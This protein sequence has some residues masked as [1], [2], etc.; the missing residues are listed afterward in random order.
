MKFSYLFKQARVVLTVCTLAFAG[1]FCGKTIPV[2]EMSE[3]RLQ[4]EAAEQEE[5]PQHSP[6]NYEQARDALLSA[7]KSLGEEDYDDARVSAVQATDLAIAAR[8]QAAPLMMA[9]RQAK[10]SE[11]LEAADEAYAE[12]LAAQDFAAAKSLYS[13]GE[14]AKAAAAEKGDSSELL[15]DRMAVLT[16][17]NTAGRKFTDAATAAERA[18]NMSLAQKG[19]MLDSLDGIRSNLKKAEAWGAGDDEVNEL[20]AA[21]ATLSQAEKEINAGELKKANGTMQEAETLSKALLAK[22]A[23]QHAQKK[24]AEA[25]AAVKKADGDFA[26]VNTENNR[27]DEEARDIL[28]TINAQ[29]TAAKEA[30]DSAESYYNRDNAQQSISESEDAI[31]L[32]QIIF[33]QHNLLAAAQKRDPGEIGEG[34]DDTDAEGDA[35]ADEKPEGWREYTVVRKSPADCLWC[36]AKRTE[37]YGNGRL[38]N[39][40]YQA[41]KAKIKNPNRIYPGQRLWIPPKSGDLTRPEPAIKEEEE[42][43]VEASEEE[44]TLMEKVEEK[45]DE[46][47]EEAEDDSMDSADSEEQPAESVE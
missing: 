37:I 9:D 26:A 20:A 38:W 21:R 35:N 5:A 11:A 8:E 1:V 45:I 32:S 36:I 7:H 39:R 16:D 44:S 34:G 13:E 10:A 19:D 29:L 4:L 30:R 27:K 17:Y 42:V 3:A 14:Q 28:E 33:E 12:V 15:E 25:T 2:Q 24:L 18:K 43:E 31:R 46:A 6:Q 22:V 47:L 40:I 23:A 41:N